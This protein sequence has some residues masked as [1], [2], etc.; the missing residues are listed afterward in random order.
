M[1]RGS[2]VALSFAL[3]GTVAATN[4]VVRTQSDDGPVVLADFPDDAPGQRA[5]GWRPA[6]SVPEGVAGSNAAAARSP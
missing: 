6:V 5:G 3:V 2:L 1:K 4:F